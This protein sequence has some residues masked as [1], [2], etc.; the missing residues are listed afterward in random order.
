MNKTTV[1][2][3]VV[4]ILLILGGGAFFFLNKSSQNSNP[5]K[6]VQNQVAQMTT[7]H[8]SIADFFSM[9]G[10]QKCTFSDKSNN[11]SGTLYIGDSK[12]RGDFQSNDSGTTTSTHMINDG[13]YVYVWVDGQKD[14]YKMSTSIVKKEAA[15]VTIGPDNNTPSVAQPS[16][17]PVNMNQQADYSCGSWSVDTSMFTLPQGVTFTDYSSMLQG[18]TPGAMMRSQGLTNEQ[19]QSM[20][21]QCNQVPA[22]AMRNQ[23]LA[24]LKCQ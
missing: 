9:T 12:M 24:Q 11:S 23:C 14:G 2:I 20:C 7:E 22:G 15:Q 16:T 19:K 10:S 18:V 5:I 3:G 13:K 1:I 8:K 4:I 21:A 6:A 17:G